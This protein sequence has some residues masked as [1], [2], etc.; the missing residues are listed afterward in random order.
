M[1]QFDRACANHNECV[2]RVIV[3]VRC[4]VDEPPQDASAVA[5][6][7]QAVVACRINNKLIDRIGRWRNGTTDL[8]R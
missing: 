3:F 5:P 8:A 2:Q 7:T 1:A 4:H 6:D